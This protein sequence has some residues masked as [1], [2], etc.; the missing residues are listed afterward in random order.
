LQNGGGISAG[1]CFST[2]KFVDRVHVSVDQ[3]GALGPPWTDGRAFR[4]GGWGTTARS[5]ELFIRPLSAPK[6]ADGG[7]KGSE[8]H[9]ELGS[10]FTGARAAL[11]RPG[12]GGAEPEGDDTR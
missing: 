6:L 12:D 8:E 3:P 4:G 11:W 10:G 1:N 9:G 5:P 7:A 2:N